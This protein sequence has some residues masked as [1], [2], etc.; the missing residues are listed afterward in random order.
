MHE[1]T[2]IMKPVTHLWS[3]AYVLALLSIYTY[4]AGILARSRHQNEPRKQSEAFRR[5]TPDPTTQDNQKSKATLER[6]P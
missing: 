6:Q 1:P 3:A 4:I 5:Q 2:N